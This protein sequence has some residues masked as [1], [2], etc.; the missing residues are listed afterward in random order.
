MSEAGVFLLIVGVWLGGAAF[1]AFLLALFFDDPG[2]TYMLA[3]CWWVL[4]PLGLMLAP[5]WGAIVLGEWTRRR[6]VGNY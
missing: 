3:L 4:L 1:C 2:P 5:I 6:N